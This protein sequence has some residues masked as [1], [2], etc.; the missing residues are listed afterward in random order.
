MLE[1][2]IGECF[3]KRR[4]IIVELSFE[5]SDTEVVDIVE[6]SH[7]VAGFD[8][9]SEGVPQR[10]GVFEEMRLA[11]RGDDAV[12]PPLVVILV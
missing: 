6:V 2:E 8:H 9:L 7:P 10:T 4:E 11:S 12:H 1:G 3:T 5:D